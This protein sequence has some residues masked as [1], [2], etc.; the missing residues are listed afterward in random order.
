MPRRVHLLNTQDFA[1]PGGSVT[2]VSAVRNLGFYLDGTFSMADHVNR[3][4]K[5][6]FYQLR[7]LKAIRHSIPTS[8]AM[9]L[10]NSFIISKMDYCNGLLAGT[11]SHHLDRIQSILNNTARLIYGKTRN[12]HVTPLLRDNLNWLRVPERVTF[13][14]CL[15]MYKTL[16]GIAPP[17]LADFCVQTVSNG[18]Y[19]LRSADR[20]RLNVPRTKTRFGERAF[21]VAGPSLWNSLPKDV[22]E[23]RSLEAFKTSLKT[24]LFSSSFP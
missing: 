16:N 10:A 23:A 3:L 7:R 14:I 15:T 18:N 5:D 22:T 13:K 1:L 24:F 11:A 8:T 6:C 2:P 19:R 4:V 20:H 12:D 21:G 9:K 17:Y